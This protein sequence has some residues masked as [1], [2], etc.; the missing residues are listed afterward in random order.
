MGCDGLISGRANVKSVDQILSTQLCVFTLISMLNK[1]TKALRNIVEIGN[2]L[3]CGKLLP[4]SSI[5][6]HISLLDLIP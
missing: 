3:F 5:V 2:L 1:Q 4:G 6:L